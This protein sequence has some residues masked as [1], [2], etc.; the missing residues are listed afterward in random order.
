MK[1]HHTEW[2]KIFANVCEKSLV[3]RIY[4][5]LIQL[6]NKN[7]NK[8][9]KNWAV[10]LKIYFSIEGTEMAKKN[11]KRCSTSLAIREMQI[12]TVM[13]HHFISTGVAINLKF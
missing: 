7:I 10:D 11:M 6:N 12:K 4:H 9:I 3:P 1:K 13:R 5:E 8:P 2:R